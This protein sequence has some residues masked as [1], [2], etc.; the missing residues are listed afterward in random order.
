MFN[1]FFWV[2]IKVFEELVHY[3]YFIDD[4]ITVYSDLFMVTVSN[5]F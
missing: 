4:K 2:Y 3:F 5:G 1:I